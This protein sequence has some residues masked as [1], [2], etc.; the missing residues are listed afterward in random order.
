MKTEVYS[1]RLDRRLKEALERA[2]RAEACSVGSL[3]TRI[4]GDW[5]RGDA[6]MAADEQAQARVREEASAYLGSV[7]GGDPRR[8]AEASR[9]VK[10]QLRERHAR[11]R[12]D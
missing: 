10:R 5:L 7:S 12:A 9:R 1:W 2:S 4:V 11:R 3:L 8:A 6:G